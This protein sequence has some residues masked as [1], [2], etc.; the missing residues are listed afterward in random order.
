MSLD[1]CGDALLW[2]VCSYMLNEMLNLS[3]VKEVPIS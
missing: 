3:G 1:A 2:R